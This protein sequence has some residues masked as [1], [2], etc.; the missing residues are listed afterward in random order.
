MTPK[1]RATWT[2]TISPAEPPDMLEEVR[3]LPPEQI[4]RE[5]ELFRSE[6]DEMA[7]EEAV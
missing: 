3:H 6:I 7:E 4:A 2:R 5:L 1:A